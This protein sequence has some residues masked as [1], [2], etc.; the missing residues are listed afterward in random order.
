MVTNLGIM[1]KDT[2]YNN[3]MN[4]GKLF[5]GALALTILLTALLSI[6]TVDR[7]LAEKY[8][9]EATLRGQNEVTPVE[10]SAI[11]EA[12]FTIPENNTMK[13]RVNITGIFN[14]SAANIYMGKTG[15]N[16]DIIV[17]LLN[18][19]TSKGT[20]TAFGMIFRGNITDSSLKGPMQ[21]KSLDDLT[22]AMESS[23]TYVNIHTSEHPD[24]EIRGQLSNADKPKQGSDNSTGVGFSTL[25]E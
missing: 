7:I 14:A 8:P 4:S 12:E 6:S 21:G 9:Y 11:G 13:Y 24:G 10:T 17:D 25:T 18:T 2:K 5:A 22:T 1:I 15:E 23:D 3:D 19:P 20:D 16:G